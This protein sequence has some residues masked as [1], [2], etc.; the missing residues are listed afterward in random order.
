MNFPFESRPMG[1][2]GVIQVVNVGLG[3]WLSLLIDNHTHDAPS[4]RK[5]K[6]LNR[7]SFR[8][9]RHEN[10]P[11]SDLLHKPSYLLE[12]AVRDPYLVSSI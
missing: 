5:Q 7:L 1:L 8:G 9:R 11:P 12:P 4:F 3:D 6:M 2:H 10:N